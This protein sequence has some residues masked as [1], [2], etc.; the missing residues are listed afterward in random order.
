MCGING[1]KEVH[2]RL[3]HRDKIEKAQTVLIS[4]QEKVKEPKKKKKYQLISRKEQLEKNK[5]PNEVESN[6]EVQKDQCA[7]NYSCVLE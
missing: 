5:A 7:Q 4:S 3:L 6:E 1:C 2:H